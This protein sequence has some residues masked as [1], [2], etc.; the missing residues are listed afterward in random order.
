MGLHKQGETFDK[1]GI[2]MREL[3]DIFCLLEEDYGENGYVVTLA[4][5]EIYNETVYDW[6]S[7]HTTEKTKSEQ[8]S[9]SCCFH[10]PF[11]D[12]MRSEDNFLSIAPS[13]N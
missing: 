8:Q 1:P 2:I 4:F 10:N 9:K 5:I 11:K 12:K 13:W 3:V 6:R 7:P